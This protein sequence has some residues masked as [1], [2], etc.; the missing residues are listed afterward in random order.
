[1]QPVEGLGVHGLEDR[2]G[3][4]DADQVEQG[5]RPHR[6]AAAELHGG[7]DVLAG[8]VLRLVHRGRLV[9][10]AEQQSVGDEAGAVAD[11]DGLLAE[12][13]GQVGDGADRRGRG[14]HRRDDLDELHRGRRIEEVQAE[15]ALGVGRVGGQTRH[16]EGVGTG[17]QDGV[18]AHDAVQRA[19]DLLL[20]VVRLRGHLD[21][22]VGVGR[23]GEVGGGAEAAED[24]LAL[25]TGE[26]FAPHGAGGGGFERGDGLDGRGLADVDADDV[27]AGAGEDLGDA[28]AHGAEADDG[29]G[30]E[31]GQRDVGLGSG[32]RGT[33]DEGDD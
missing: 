17:G 25:L 2:T 5:E 22:Q 14:Q 6:Q 8:G 30:L 7:V 21:D 9:Q 27:A 16:G 4:V 18:R 13:E 29:D 28:G 3:R 19:E 1:M 23:G 11:R 12:V 26:P 10:V 20:D 32:H 31:R 33:P 24:V 15:D